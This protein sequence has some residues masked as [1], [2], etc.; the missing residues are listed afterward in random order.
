MCALTS[1]PSP[2]R[3]PGPLPLLMGTMVLSGLLPSGLSSGAYAAG[4]E[5]VYVKGDVSTLPRD[6]ATWSKAPELVVSLMAQPMIIPR[7]K[8]TTTREVKVQAIHDGHWIA[9][10]LSWEDSER[11]DGGPLGKFSDSCAIEFPG[12]A[13]GSPPPVFMGAKDNPVH[14]LHWRAQYQVDREQGLKE[15]KD[16]Y[17][18]MQID[19]YPMEYNDMGNIS[20]IGSADREVY[21]PGLASGNPQSYR[22]LRGVD[23]I[24]AEGFGSSTI[25]QNAMAVGEGEWKDRRW[26]VVIARPLA[27]ENGSVLLEGGDTFLG[28]AIWQGGKDEV[29]SRKS[30]TMSW[31]PMHIN[32][33]VDGAS[34]SGAMAPATG[35][36][37][38][39]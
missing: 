39:K 3:F 6:A 9:F 22:K 13:G 4:V 26:T 14:I 29:G 25:A 18:N 17:P 33:G 21:S 1:N 8:I 19:M 30:V 27:R 36:T 34:N 16:Y 11:S 31:T 15:P 37:G 38:T 23:E 35:T 10:R 32:M 5:A 24:I 2:R 12:R 7:P 20:T 28:F